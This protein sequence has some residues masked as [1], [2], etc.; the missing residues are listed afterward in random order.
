MVGSGRAQTRDRVVGLVAARP[1]SPLPPHAPDFDV[2]HPYPQNCSPQLMIGPGPGSSGRSSSYASDAFTA[3]TVGSSSF[4]V[5][6]T[7]RSVQRSARDV[8]QRPARARARVLRESEGRRSTNSPTTPD[9]PS[10]T[11]PSP[12]ETSPTS[13]WLQLRARTPGPRGRLEYFRE[14]KCASTRDP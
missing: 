5:P 11:A 6:S 8:N 10:A 7:A 14:S 1:R 9:W 4:T 2:T 13:R 3:S 12:D